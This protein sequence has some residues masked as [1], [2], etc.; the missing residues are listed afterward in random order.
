[1]VDMARIFKFRNL[2]VTLFEIVLSN[3]VGEDFGDE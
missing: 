2:C 3:F 1:M